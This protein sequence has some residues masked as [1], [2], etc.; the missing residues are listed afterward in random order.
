M[1][2]HKSRTPLLRFR[3]PLR[4]LILLG[5]TI[6][7]TSGAVFAQ[8]GTGPTCYDEDNNQI[9]CATLVGDLGEVEGA[10]VEC[11][12]N[13]YKYNTFT[14]TYEREFNKFCA[15][16]THD[17]NEVLFHGMSLFEAQQVS[18][19]AGLT[20]SQTVI[21]SADANTNTGAPGETTQSSLSHPGPPELR[22]AD[23]Y[24]AQLALSQ[25]Q[26]NLETSEQGQSRTQSDETNDDWA[27]VFRFF[28]LGLQ[29][30][31]QGRSQGTQ[32]F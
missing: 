14:A 12:R 3:L 1:K 23:Q 10:S 16:Y 6:S 17:P 24:Q 4:I 26:N 21:Q 5:A 11:G 19:A 28:A 29:Q 31:Q 7:V 9:D 27:G 18:Q 13:P 30:A 8:E 15:Q 32:S 20:G 25:V 2:S 22:A